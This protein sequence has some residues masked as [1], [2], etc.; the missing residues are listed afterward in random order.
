MQEKDT[1]RKELYDN[2]E[3]VNLVACEREKY[4]GIA[5]LCRCGNMHPRVSG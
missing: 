2:K 1:L 3:T 5:A 4:M